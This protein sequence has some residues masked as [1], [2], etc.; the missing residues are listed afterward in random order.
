ML[1]NYKSKSISRNDNNY[2]SQSNEIRQFNQ[3][4]EYETHN[5]KIYLTILLKILLNPNKNEND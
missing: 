3:Y 2:Q 5:Y 4:K 1:N